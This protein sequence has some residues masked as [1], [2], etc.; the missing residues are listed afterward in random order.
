MPDPHP[1]CHC[2]QRHPG[3]RYDPSRISQLWSRRFRHHL[4]RSRQLYRTNHELLSTRGGGRRYYLVRHLPGAKYN[5]QLELVANGVDNLTTWIV[6]SGSSKI[7]WD[8]VEGAPINSGTTPGA[9]QVTVE[10]WMSIIL[11]SRGRRHLQ[12]P[13]I[14]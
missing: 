12:L 10:V 3:Q 13:N 2:R 4:A 5:G 1:S 7:I 11:G 6:T 8:F 9:A 14:G